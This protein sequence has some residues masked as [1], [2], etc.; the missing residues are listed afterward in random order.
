VRQ[1]VVASFPQAAANFIEL[2][3]GTIADFVECEAV[4][5]LKK[6]PSKPL[7]F[8]GPQQ[9]SYSQAALVAPGKIAITGEQLGFH[10]Q[11]SDV[12]LA[13]DRLRKTLDTVGGSYKNVAMMHTYSLTR[14]TADQIRKL[15]FDYVDAANPPASTLLLF[16]GLPSLDASFAFDLITVIP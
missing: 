11:D 16:E 6:A 13:F 12:K 9:G 14:K 5:A 3:R 8:V 15:R 2:Q 1:Q 10:Q 4:A 7:I